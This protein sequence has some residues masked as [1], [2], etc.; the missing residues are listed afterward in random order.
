[1]SLEN[2]TSPEV[3]ID[4]GDI[5]DAL[6]FFREIL[7]TADLK[8]VRMFFSTFVEAINRRADY[9]TTHPVIE[10]IFC[11]PYWYKKSVP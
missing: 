2:Q 6:E 3:R 10:P 5:D 8:M 4:D 9:G 1:M 11:S 7:K